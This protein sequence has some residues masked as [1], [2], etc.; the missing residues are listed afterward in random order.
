MGSYRATWVLLTNGSD[1]FTRPGIAAV[2]TETPTTPHLRPW[3]DD[4]S[5][6]LP[7]VQ[8]TKH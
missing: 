1:F 3:T 5:S 7:I 2:S 8:L 4:Y 6:L